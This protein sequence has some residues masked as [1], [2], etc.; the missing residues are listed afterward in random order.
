VP[1]T[2]VAQF[3]P[4]RLYYGGR[5]DAAAKLVDLARTL[6]ALEPDPR[7]FLA[8]LGRRGAG[9]RRG[10]LWFLDAG[11]GGRNTISGTGVKP[12]FDDGTRGQ[13]RHFTGTAAT[14]A[15]IGS[16]ATRWATLH[17]LRDGPDTADGRL[18]EAAIAFAELLLSGELEPRDAADWIARNILA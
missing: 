13:I 10:P 3:E 12:E 7:R 9:V 6:G 17:I 14:V 18:S 1:L 8:E 11:R 2:F 15:R 16:R 5:V 4:I